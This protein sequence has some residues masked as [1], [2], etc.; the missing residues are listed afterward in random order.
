MWRCRA[1]TAVLTAVLVTAGCSTDIRGNDDTPSP[2]QPLV[3][4]PSTDVTV[5]AEIGVAHRALIISQALYDRAAVVVLADTGEPDTYAEAAG[6]AVDLGVPLLLS[7]TADGIDI[8]LQ[9][10]LTRLQTESVLAMGPNA[11]AWATGLDGIVG[12]VSDQQV[13][14]ASPVGGSPVGASLPEVE[15]PAPLASVTVLTSTDDMGTDNLAALATARAAGA[16]VLVTDTS[17]PRSD[18][19][20]IAA[21]AESPPTHTIALG[22]RFGHADLL[23]DRLAVAATG[24]Q[25]PGG[26]QVLFPGRRL[27]ALYGHPGSNVLGALGEQPLEQA[28][29]R[30]Q[31]V[32][33]D[34]QELVDEPVVPTF[35]IIT[36]IASA[37]PGPQGDYSTRTPIE[38]L[39]PWIDAARDA[40]IYVVLDLQPGHTDF[41]TQAKEYE[42]LLIEPHV[43]LA[44][45]PEWRLAPGQ[46]HMVQ[47][48]SVDAAEVNEVVE[49]LADLTAQHHLP[50]KLL[51]VHQ[52]QLRMISD[53]ADLDTGRDEVAVM[54]HA[55][56]FG[57]PGAK[58]AT[59]RAL[60][61]EAPDVWWGW[62][63]F[64]DEDTPTMSPA[65][66]VAVEPS[67]LFIS[68]Q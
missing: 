11:I 20:L 41:L 59:W 61:F 16:R 32:A 28:I 57:S 54:I 26:G 60:H 53:R 44:L 10:E 35:E 25:L 31:R 37:T 55:D 68:Y 33:S 48:G 4:P 62:K 8:A 19:E 43:G 63:N 7:S 51:I 29:A 52:F 6:A 15:P 30:A 58:H 18:P 14:L 23:R 65:D 56:G 3:S 66:T 1:L 40:G 21:L 38:T 34:Y 17:D 49:W 2:T 13:A 46:R 45:D 24:V 9:D 50:Q 22:A 47:I 36:T 12:V 5:V 27:V 67:P 39:R 42:E 64:Y